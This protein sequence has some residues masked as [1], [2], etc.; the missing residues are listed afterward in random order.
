MGQRGR[1]SGGFQPWQIRVC[2]QLE[3]TAL[4]ADYGFLA[5]AGSYRVV[6]NTDATE[7][8]GFG[9]ADDNVRHFTQADPLYEKD[10]KGWLKLYLPARSAVVLEKED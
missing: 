4:I 9:I 5:P 10:G 2:L 7:F 3:R 8:A 6:L 1:P